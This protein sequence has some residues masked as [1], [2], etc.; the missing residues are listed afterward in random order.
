[1]ANQSTRK[2]NGPRAGELDRAPSDQGPAEV[3][4]VNH[5][6]PPPPQLPQATPPGQ[7]PAFLDEA[8]GED[9]GKGVS[10]A[11]A[12]NIVPMIKVL[13][14]QSPEVLNGGPAYVVGAEMGMI[15]VKGLGPLR[16]MVFQSCHFDK[17]W[18]EWR[19]RGGGGGGGSGFVARHNNRVATAREAAQFPP[20]V[21]EVVKAGEDIPDLPLGDLSFRVNKDTRQKEWYR[22][23][24]M[25]DLVQTRYHAGF[26]SVGSQV[27]PAVVPFTS[28]GHAVSKQWMFHIGCQRDGKGQIYPSF[29]KVYRL[30][31]KR[32][33]NAKGTWFVIEWE[34]AGFVD[35]AAYLRGRA[36]NAAFGSG[37]MVAD[38]DQETRD[39]AG[40][41]DQGGGDDP[42]AWDP[43]IAGSMDDAPLPY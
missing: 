40:A 20:V 12:D 29:A 11:S 35:Y 41:P 42:G 24:T 3:A 10:T 23:S 17:A 18:P 39:E 34:D 31:T 14:P 13:Q 22:T 21:G 37:E 7:P 15:L 16:E 2:N 25:N 4:N 9:A 6:S 5:A 26:A 19:P 27:V 32:K 43:G 33:Q 36:L 28:T 38:S 30:T 8:M 1:M